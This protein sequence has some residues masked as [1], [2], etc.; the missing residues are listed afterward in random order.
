MHL[1]YEANKVSYNEAIDGEIVKALFEEKSSSD[2]D[3]PFD[4][5]AIYFLASINYEFPPYSPS[6][7][8]GDGEKFDGGAKVLKYVLERESLQLWLDNGLSFDIKHKT[9]EKTSSK[10]KY[11]FARV[12]KELD[13]A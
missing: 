1:S 9:S 11:F 3:D 2:S 7:E 4:T 8:W 6:I 5:T 12:F 13:H 10:I